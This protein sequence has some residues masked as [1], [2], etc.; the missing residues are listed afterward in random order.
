MNL[1]YVK[2]LFKIINGWPSLMDSKTSYF[3]DTLNKQN[4]ILNIF[5]SLGKT[6]GR[7]SAGYFGNIPKFG[8]SKC[9]HKI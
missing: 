1:I 3:L 9:P 6:K 4:I 5:F 2:F 8:N 7:P